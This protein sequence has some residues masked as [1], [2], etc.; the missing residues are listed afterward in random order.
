MKDTLLPFS[1]KDSD[2]LCN[3][4]EVKHSSHDRRQGVLTLAIIRNADLAIFKQI[5]QLINNKALGKVEFSLVFNKNWFD[6][7]FQS[8]S[9]DEQK[10]PNNCVPFRFKINVFGRDKQK[11]ISERWLTLSE[12][13]VGPEQETFRFSDDKTAADVAIYHKYREITALLVLL[14]QTKQA[15]FNG[16]INLRI[17]D[18][19]RF[20][21]DAQ[22]RLRQTYFS[23][24]H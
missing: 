23:Q 2:D 16:W 5:Q 22:R 7:F 15:E 13:M 1:L 19:H 14:A 10:K 6:I 18:F 24:P 9:E 20:F 21:V 11:Y 8:V 12:A 3:C 4:D 17:E